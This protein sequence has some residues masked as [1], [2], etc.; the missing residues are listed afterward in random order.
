[1]NELISNSDVVINFAAESFVDRSISE[2]D[3]FLV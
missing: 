1:M 3:P 2:A